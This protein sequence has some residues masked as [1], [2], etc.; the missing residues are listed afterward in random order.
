VR[1]PVLGDDVLV[2]RASREL[3]V[4]A[5]ALVAVAMLSLVALVTVVVV[6]G[7]S[8]AENALLRST[9]STADDVGDPPAGTWVVLTQADRVTASAGLPDALTRRLADLRTGE[10]GPIALTEVASEDGAEYRV[11]TLRGRLRTVQVVLDLTAEHAQRDRLLAAMGGASVLALLLAGG[12]GVLLGR[13][14]VRP[15]AQALA[16]QRAFVAD[17]SHELRTPLTLLSTRAQLLDATV[18][19][20]ALPEQ[21]RQD[22]ASLI[23]D[24]Q[25]LGEVL[26]DLLVAADPGRQE[27]LTEVL[28]E[29]VAVGAVES[30]RP[31]AERAGVLLV[32][33]ASEGLGVLAAEPALR[34]AV[35]ALID[36]AIDHTPREGRVTV[37]CE[38]VRRD[39]VLSVNDT[40]PGIAPDKQTEVLRRFHSGGHRAG[41]AHYGLGLAL[42]HDVAN[43]L[44]G[45]LRVVSSAVGATFELVLP[46]VSGST[47]S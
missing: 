14:A 9:A 40:G 44:G 24:V 45:Q 46:A 32:V 26:E 18:Q 41:R 35:L 47:G 7:Q 2:R 33:N 36:N 29:Q 17:A 13:R 43:R 31:H 39:V 25:R 8:S 30:A 12:L 21:A 42:T 38:R 28:V 4:R 22:S 34:R 16:L 1:A 20:S 15:F 23:A 6:R 5:A 19:R 37:T 3:A 27:L 11:A 10:P